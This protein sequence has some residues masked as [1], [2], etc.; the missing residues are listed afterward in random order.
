MSHD[1][2]IIHHVCVQFP[3]RLNFL[4]SYPNISKACFV[5]NALQFK[6]G[7]ELDVMSATKTATP[8]LFCSA[9][10]DADT[11]QQEINNI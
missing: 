10:C 4:N 7:T 1:R 9:T 3:K 8:G 2:L 11:A 6:K 5:Q